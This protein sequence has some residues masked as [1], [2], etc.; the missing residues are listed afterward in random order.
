MKSETSACILEVPSDDAA[1][2]ALLQEGAA[3]YVGF[4][5]VVDLLV[6]GLLLT[7]T[8]PLILVLMVAVKLTSPGPA[9]Y[10]QLRLGRHGRP[11]RIY[12]LRTMIHNCE[13]LTGPR[14]ATAGD[15]RVTPFGR[16]LRRSHLD[17]LPQLWNIL[18]GEMSLVG[19]RPE[20]PEFAS[21]LEKVI[22]D[23]SKRLLVR[24]GVTGLA[25]IQ[26]PADTEVDG[27]HRKVT[28]DLC[29]IERMNLWLDAKIVVG[30]AM[31]VAGTPFRLIRQVLALPGVVE[32]VPAAPAFGVPEVA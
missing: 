5:T 26:L 28:C 31:K 9:F 17:E 24:P 13:R 27:V 2:E 19:P 6:A 29:Y 23:Y 8:A 30:T 20:R 32:P 11:F 18:R 12:K 4:K 22:P 16:F 3:W 14:W 7:L 15:P 25:Q 1:D 21:Q 10:S